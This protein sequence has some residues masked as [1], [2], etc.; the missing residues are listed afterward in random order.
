MYDLVEQGQQTDAVQVQVPSEMHSDLGL[1]TEYFM[2][3]KK[4]IK[5]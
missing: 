4:L 3:A 2:P 5:K 1:A